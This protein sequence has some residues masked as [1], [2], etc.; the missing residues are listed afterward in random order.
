MT[1]I[2]SD[3]TI[4]PIEPAEWP[5]LHFIWESS[6]DTDDPAGRPPEGWWFLGDWTKTGVVLLNG[7]TPLGLA[8][9]RATSDPAA[10]EVRLAVLPQYRQPDVVRLLVEAVFE[11]ARQAGFSSARFFISGG[12]SWATKTVAGYGIEF[13]RDYHA[14][15]LPATIEVPTVAMPDGVRLRTLA[16]GE[17]EAALAALNRA[18]ATTWNFRPI[19][20]DALQN[21]FKD[22]QR[23]GFLVAVPQSDETLIIGT[24]H[25]ILDPANH[26]YDGGIY[27]LISNLTNDPDWRGRGLGR[28]L[29]TAGV[30]NLRDRGATSVALGVDG[31][32]PVPVALY[33]SI[34]F[35]SISRLEVWAGKIPELL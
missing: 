8:A 5:R 30:R 32:N 28:A 3:Y 34:G 4:R 16:D 35:E 1:D 14:M 15:L 17:D 29:L 31:G 13:F 7:A 24:C 23:N 12:G 33:R 10:V 22:G 11:M 27:A 26:N 9:Y 21:D 19:T 25:A 2:L 6:Q 20:M 18:W